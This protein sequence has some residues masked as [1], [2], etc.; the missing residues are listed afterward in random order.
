M[1]IRKAILNDLDDILSIYSY[2]RIY[3]KENGNPNQWNDNHHPNKDYVINHI[4][5]DSLYVIVNDLEIVGVFVF[6]IGIDNTY[7]EIN[8]SWLN[9]NEY[10]VIHGLAKKKGHNHIFDFAISYAKAKCNNLRIDTHKD[11]H[12]MQYLINKSG[13]KYCGIIHVEDKTE[14]LAYQ[15]ERKNIPYEKY[16]L[17]IVDYDGTIISSME[18]WKNTCSSFLKSKGIKYSLDV[19]DIVEKM[20]S[21]EACEYITNTYFKGYTLDEVGDMM[22]DF[23]EEEYK[24][25]KLKPNALA[26][27]SK[28][29]EYGK[30]VLYSA[31]AMH[32]LNKSLDNL[33]IK[34]YFSYIYSGSEMGWNKGDGSGFI[35]LIN[36]ERINKEECLVVEDAIHAILGAKKVNI[37]I[38]GVE[39]TM[40]QDKLADIYLNSTYFLPLN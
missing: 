13:F 31:T 36:E 30:I 38:L 9:D 11:N 4:K 25:Q 26:M 16:K 7:N 28:M 5:S 15:F 19:D 10:G 37:D 14:R 17:F 3:M 1:E 6:F 39:D 23:I 8:G 33:G 27:L 18:M 2:A 12:I 24:N 29:K 22:T 40:N 20:T 35:S 21:K 34:D 32:L